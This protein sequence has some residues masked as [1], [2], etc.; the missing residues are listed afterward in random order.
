MHVKAKAGQ[1]PE[2]ARLTGGAVTLLGLLEQ[3]IQLQLLIVGDAVRQHAGGV[4]G[5]LLKV[6]LQY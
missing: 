3:S 6:L 2:H 4:L 1:V 5:S